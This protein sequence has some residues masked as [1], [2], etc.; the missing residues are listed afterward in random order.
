MKTTIV[1]IS[2]LALLCTACSVQQPTLDARKDICLLFEEKPS[3][4]KDLRRSEIKHHVPLALAAAIVQQESSFKHAAKPPYTTYFLGLIP[5]SRASSAEGYAQV[6][7]AT[8]QRYLE[9]NNRYSWWASRRSF[10]DSVDF[11]GWYINEI[12]DRTKLTV[13]QPKDIYLAYHEG[14]GGY[15]KQSYQNKPVLLRASKQVE[16]R[17]YRY[18]RQWDQCQ[19]KV[20]SKF[21]FFTFFNG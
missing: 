9:S 6:I 14:P 17:A 3:W 8:W 16:E 2:T 13:H 15:L 5:W 20:K 10:S 1:K 11:I 7:D 19:Q 21:P 18:Q 4:Y 12:M